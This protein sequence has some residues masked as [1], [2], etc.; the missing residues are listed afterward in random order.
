MRG[1]ILA[2]ENQQTIINDVIEVKR[3]CIY[4][5]L[6]QIQLIIMKNTQSLSDEKLYAYYYLWRV[7]FGLSAIVFIIGFFSFLK[8]FVAM[9]I[10]AKLLVL[11]MILHIM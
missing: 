1:S 6:K 8:I 4:I 9:E 3:A 10:T 7:V 5:K 2:T 11:D